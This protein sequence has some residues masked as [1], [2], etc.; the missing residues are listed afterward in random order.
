MLSG[1][2]SARSRLIGIPPIVGALTIA[3]A[4]MPSLIEP[5][6]S[7]DFAKANAVAKSFPNFHERGES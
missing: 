2:P 6:Q 4:L 5:P 3:A 1:L 7:V